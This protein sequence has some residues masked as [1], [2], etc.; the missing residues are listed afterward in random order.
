MGCGGQVQVPGL[1]LM[2]F[3]QTTQGNRL[4]CRDQEGRRGSEGAVPGPSVFP[5]REPG[6]IFIGRSNLRSQRARSRP[7][8]SSRLQSRPGTQGTP[9]RA[10]STTFA[11][12]P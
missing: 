10:L 9:P 2:G 8:L 1:F 6:G 5:S 12:G 3:I 11:L 4:S 7:K